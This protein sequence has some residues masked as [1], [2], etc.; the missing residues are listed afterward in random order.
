MADDGQIDIAVTS[1]NGHMALLVDDNGMGVPRDDFPH[2]FAPF[3]RA[4]GSDQ[5]GTGL[6]LAIVKAIA[7]RMGGTVALGPRPSGVSGCRFTLC[8]M[9]ARIE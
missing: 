5:E 7:D 1:S 4:A 8:C 3:Y 9:L 6:G 2:V